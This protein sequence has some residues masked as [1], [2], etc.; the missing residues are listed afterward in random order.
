LKNAQNTLAKSI[1]NVFK[2]SGGAGTP[3]TGTPNSW[4]WN[5]RSTWRWYNSDGKAQ[6]DV[7]D[8]DHKGLKPH[9]HDWD[10]SGETPQRQVNPHPV[11]DP[12]P[13]DLENMWVLVW[14]PLLRVF[15]GGG[16]S[17]TPQK[18]AYAY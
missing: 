18:S 4:W 15:M 8:Y 13:P 1:S 6:Y 12:L 9:Q 2:F 10:W 7:D 11:S 17:L 5:E 3:T 16:D 14:L